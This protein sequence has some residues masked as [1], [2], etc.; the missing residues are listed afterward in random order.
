MAYDLKGSF[1]S[2]RELSERAGEVGRRAT[3]PNPKLA[4]AHRSLGSALLSLGQFDAAV[5]AITEAVRL[6][7]DDAGAHMSLACA[8]WVGQGNVEGGIAELKHAIVI[9]PDLGYAH[10]Q[11]GLL[12][13]L[14]GNF[15]KAERSCRVAV[16][17]QDRF[18][19]GKE[20]PC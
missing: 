8:Y 18:L 15:V 6:E 12:Y 10:L 9:N 17:L 16:D 11:L 4:D 3:E 19:S 14:R 13:A 5:D 2:Q 20:G 7:P 1:M